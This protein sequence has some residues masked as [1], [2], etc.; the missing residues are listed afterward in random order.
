MTTPNGAYFRNKLPRFS[1]CPDPSLYESVQFKP[2]ADGHIFLLH[3]DE[4]LQLASRA[5]LVVDQLR[6]FT[7]SLTNGHIKLN[8][9]LRVLPHGLVASI[10]A[11]TQHLS[12][13]MAERLM[14]HMG[15][16]LRKPPQA[17][18]VS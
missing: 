5:G 13:P 1:D 3:S 2:D 10:E 18:A 7:N 12:R 8:S 16:R 4:V 9:L 6:L 14:V 15:V 17:D 11:A